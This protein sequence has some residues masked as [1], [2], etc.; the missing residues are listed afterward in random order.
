VP[1]GMF[2][3]FEYNR[4]G[5]NMY[6]VA[7]KPAGSGIAEPPMRPEWPL[8]NFAL[9]DIGATGGRLEFGSSLDS[10]GAGQIGA[11]VINTN[12]TNLAPQTI[13]AFTGDQFTVAIDNLDR[14]GNP[15]IRPNDQTAHGLDWRDRGDNPLGSD[16]FRHPLI[17]MGEDLVKNNA[18]I[19]R[20]T[21]GNLPAGTYEVTSFHLDPSFSQADNIQVLVD[22][23]DGRGWV[24]TEAGDRESR[25]NIEGS[26]WCWLPD[27][28]R[29]VATFHHLSIH[30]RRHK[31]R[32]GSLRRSDS[33]DNT[34]RL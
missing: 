25:W 20:V 3:T 22:V 7:V 31:Q 9:V 4:G 13:N 15:S 6:G 11:G 32:E 30:C 28:G 8:P 33:L 29:D 19:V 16:T 1:A 23:G 5:H 14:S 21:L 18:G 34:G 27:D 2:S 10:L 24:D 17:R 12:N 26:R